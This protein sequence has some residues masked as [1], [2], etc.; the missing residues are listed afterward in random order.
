MQDTA[1][2]E[3]IVALNKRL[4]EQNARLEQQLELTQ[5]ELAQLKKHIFGR[6]SEKER[7]NVPGQGVLFSEEQASAP[8]PAEQEYTEVKGF[9]RKRNSKKSI[10]ADLPTEERL[11]EPE[12]THCTECGDALK[13]FSRDTRTEIDFVP[14]R[15]LKR[16]HVTV[17][18]SCPGC[19]NVYSGKTP[20]ANK[21]VLPGTELGAGFLSHI[22]VSKHCDHLPYYRQSQIYEREGVLIPDKSL[23]RYGMALGSLLEPIAKEIKAELLKQGYLQADETRYEVLKGKEGKNIHRGQL[24]VL[25]DPLGKLTYYAYYPERDSAAADSVL[26]GFSGSLQ[27]DAYASYNGHKGTRLGCMTHARRYFVKVKDITPEEAG[28]VLKLIGK[29]YKIERELKKQHGNKKA[30][31]FYKIRLRVRQEKAAPLLEKLKAYLT[32]LQDTWLLAEH[33][34][35]KAINYMLSRFDDFCVYTTDGSYEID[36]NDVE[37]MIRPIAVGRKNWLFAGSPEGAKMA[38]VVMTVIQTCKQLKVNPQ[39]YLAAVLP[40]LAQHETT[41]IEGLSPFDWKKQ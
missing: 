24:W 19:K 40:I 15:F 13:E 7:Y 39:R 31:K 5:F 33:P 38:A 28:R 12:E 36:N 8:E 3:D 17:H 9:K 16:E 29:L 20:V 27:T 4:L 21:P 32:T 6:R 26:A 22:L 41:S 14:A 10:P 35:S 23:S 2:A 18:C 37:R 25:N 34:L 1:S 30:E 11:Y